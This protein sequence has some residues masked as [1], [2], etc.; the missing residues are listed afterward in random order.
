MLDLDHDVASTCCQETRTD[1]LPAAAIDFFQSSVEALWT[2]VEPL[3][4]R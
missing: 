2:D 3:T 1:I 4:R